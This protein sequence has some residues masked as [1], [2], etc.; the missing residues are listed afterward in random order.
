[1]HSPDLAGAS[2][3]QDGKF[4]T[5]RE[6][7]LHLS[8]AVET[9]QYELLCLDP[10]FA[11]WGLESAQMAQLLRAFFLRRP[12]ARIKLAL[13]E[14]HYL[15]RCP[16]F[17]RTVQAFPLACETRQT[18]RKLRELRDSF[19][20][21]DQRHIVRRYHADHMRGEAVFS[22]PEACFTPLERWRQL[23]DACHPCL[24]VFSSGI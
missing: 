20:I 21:A 11:F 12:D 14:T 9:A 4:D 15:Q 5:L 18:P 2:A 8:R 23:W 6:F 17:L 13:H 3:P 1:M 10:D 24:P 22:T 7:K 16:H 19:C